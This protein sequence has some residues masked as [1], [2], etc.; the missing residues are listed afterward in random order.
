M[1]DDT[2]S[3]FTLGVDHR[4]NGRYD[5]AEALFKSVLADE[6]DNADAHHELGLV[7]S[8]VVHDDCVPELEHAVRL[9]PDSVTFLISLAKT[10]TMFGDFDKAKPLFEKILSI[11]PFNEEA[12]KNLEYLRMF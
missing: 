3:R 7:Y 8:F 6:P 9:R 12:N 10:H 11:D 5:Q 4:I 2:A 1:A